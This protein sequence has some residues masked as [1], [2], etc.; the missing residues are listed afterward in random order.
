VVVVIVVVVVVQ[1]KAAYQ[2]DAFCDVWVR[3]RPYVRPQA[4]RNK[5]EAHHGAV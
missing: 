5:R 4:M 3:F 1:D 2:R